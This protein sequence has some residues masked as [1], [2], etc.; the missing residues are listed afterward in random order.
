VRV[1]V[2]GGT[3]FIGRA[4]VQTLGARGDEA[5]VVSR[6]PGATA[7][8]WDAIEREVE[9]A[10]AIVHLAGE[11]VAAARWTKDRVERIRE[12]R[13]HS[14]ETISRAIVRGLRKPRVFVSGSAVGIY[15]MLD[16]DRELDER[17][18]PADDT[19]A[20]ITVAWEDAASPARRAGVRV[21]HP[22]IGIVLGTGG[23]ALAK[24]ATTFRWFVGGPIG[25]GRQW[26]SWIH[27]QDAVRALLF[28][29]DCDALAGPVNV[30]A[31]EPVTMDRFAHAIGRAVHRPSAIRVP[32]FVLRLALGEGLARTL[33]TGQRALPARLLESG[34][35]F[36]FPRV[37]EACED[38]LQR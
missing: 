6:H 27:L 23:G 20:R 29:L 2:T 38:L 3:G 10:D 19:L 37:E 24:M 9:R 12:S 8:G 36:D 22:R 1:L 7:V 13:V 21:V 15:G 25:S 5:V 16:D 31:P 28:T 32:S 26:V 33:L 35:V 17:A 34:F 11:P 18:P 30:V 14:T 4:L